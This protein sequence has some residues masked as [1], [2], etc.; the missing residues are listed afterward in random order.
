MFPESKS[1]PADLGEVLAYPSVARAVAVDLFH[2]EGGILLH[3]RRVDVASVPET[4]IEKDG[5]LQTGQGDVAGDALNS[6]NRIM[7]AVAK[8]FLVELRPN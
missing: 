6:R 7:D 8:P 2:P 5:D 1:C 4:A 3:R